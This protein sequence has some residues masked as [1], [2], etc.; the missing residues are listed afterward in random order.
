MSPKKLIHRMYNKN[1]RKQAGFTL[2]ELLVVIAIIGFLSSVV[3]VALN[4]ARDRSTDVQRM[5]DMHRL[6]VD[7]NLALLEKK[8]IPAV[9]GSF[10]FDQSGQSSSVARGSDDS[11]PLKIAKYIGILPEDVSA[12]SDPLSMTLN[13]NLKNLFNS[14]NSTGQSYFRA[15]STPPEDPKCDGSNSATCYRAW[16]DGE[17]IVIATTLRTKFHSSGKNVQ[18]GVVIGK[19]NSS[20]LDR[21]CKNL[22]FPIYDTSA[23]GAPGAGNPTCTGT[24]PASIIKGVSNGLDIGGSD[25]YSY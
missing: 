10:T 22:N 23:N 5:A 17:S 11:A 8:P 25:T 19:L 15:G 9:A 16:Y 1:K 13:T 18:Y 6:E 12:V 3:S 7:A 24:A 21:A 14:S 20:L 4:K 2:I